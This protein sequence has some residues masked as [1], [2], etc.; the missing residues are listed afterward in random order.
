M[1]IK[2]PDESENSP[3]EESKVNEKIRKGSPL[4]L[5]LF[6]LLIGIAVYGSF[7]SFQKG[8]V[9][10]HTSDLEKQSKDIQAQIDTLK[11]SKVEISQTAQDA[12]KKIK[13]DEIQW[14]S[15]INDVNQLI[16]ADASGKQKIQ[17]L[18]YSGSGAGKISINVVTQPTS[19]PAFN[20]VAALISTFNN[21]VFFKNAYVP[22]ISKGQNQDGSVTLSFVMSMDY[23]KQ[24]TGSADLNFQLGGSSPVSTAPKVAAPQP[25]VSTNLT[26]TNP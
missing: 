23:Q 26:N 14:S 1:V 6:F 7:L 3:L 10:T 17:I 18:S 2:N 21:S 19:L 15:V 9:L 4:N 13:A 22:S 24:D 20:D 25:S 16:P 11:I 12:L 5:V 8:G